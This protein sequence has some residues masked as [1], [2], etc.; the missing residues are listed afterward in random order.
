[1]EKLK[2]PLFTDFHQKIDYLKDRFKS[3]P[4]IDALMASYIEFTDYWFEQ[5]LDPEDHAFRT[6]YDAFKLDLQEYYLALLEDHLNEHNE[7]REELKLCA[8]DSILVDLLINPK[9]L[10]DEIK[11]GIDD[12]IEDYRSEIGEMIDEDSNY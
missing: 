1:M 7:E 8:I 4:Y 5:Y 6:D 11:A 12:L 2:T 9:H 3:E 10:D